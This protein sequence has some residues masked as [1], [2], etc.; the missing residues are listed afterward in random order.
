MSFIRIGDIRER[1][2][3]FTLSN[4]NGLRDIERRAPGYLYQAHSGRNVLSKP[5]NHAGSSRQ[6]VQHVVLL[7]ILGSEDYVLNDMNTLKLSP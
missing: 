4:L 3:L 1:V 7:D 2:N 5:L 6:S